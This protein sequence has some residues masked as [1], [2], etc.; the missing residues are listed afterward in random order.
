MTAYGTHEKHEPSE[1]DRETAA[2][3]D[4]LLRMKRL[5]TRSVLPTLVA[6]LVAA[7][8]PRERHIRGVAC[9]ERSSLRLTQ[10]MDRPSARGPLSPAIE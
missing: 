10:R 5:R 8:A 1:S 3:H 6:S 7:R 9:R 4:L 2:L